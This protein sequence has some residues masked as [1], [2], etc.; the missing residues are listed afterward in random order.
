MKNRL[1]FLLVFLILTVYAQAGAVAQMSMRDSLKNAVRELTA[2][3]ERIADI[4]DKI[5]NYTDYE[6]YSSE[7]RDF[8]TEADYYYEGHQSF[9]MSQ[10]EKLF[11]IWSKISD[12]REAL[13]EKIS[14][15]EQEN[16][17]KELLEKLGGEFGEVKAQYEQLLQSFKKIPSMKRNPSADTLALL[18][19]KDSELYPVFSAKKAQPEV[20]ELVAQNPPLDSVSNFIETAH[21]TISEAEDIEKI[22]WG[23]IIFKVTLVSAVLFFLIN[24]I[25]SKKKLKNQLNGKKNKFTPSI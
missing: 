20:K 10:K 2:L 23:D 13:E 7:Y 22:K 15:L 12:L 17:K 1:Q 18:K 14:N 9:I 5:T 19:K 4:D 25:A 24:L 11:S 21:K 8:C 16:Q 6:V 3:Q